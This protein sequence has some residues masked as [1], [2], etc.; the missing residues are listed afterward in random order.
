MQRPAS[1]GPEN[2]TLLGDLRSE[3]S[4]ESAPLLQFIVANSKPI[5]VVV[6]LLLLA[7]AGTGIWRWQA[8][9]RAEDAL[10]A[11]AR[12]S[13]TMTGAERVKA[14]EALAA[15]SPEAFRYGV[16]TTLAHSAVEAGEP[17]RAAEAYGRAA[18]LDE[19]R[20]MGLA[21]ELAQAGVLLRA[22]KAGEALTLLQALE[23][24]MTDEQ[25]RLDLLP[26][27]A[28]AAEMAGKK[29]VAADAYARL[30]K[31]LPGEDGSYYRA[32]AA[33]LGGK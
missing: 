14:L 32:R 1:S 25:S 18:R 16:L 3:V 7:L 33:E 31:A 23:K 27:V 15:D 6:L 28:D 21:A 26:L 13:L 29:D 24:G 8:S 12:A 17:A 19:G 11:L 22:G 30:G 4:A 5:S 10:D 20:P 2:P 9:S